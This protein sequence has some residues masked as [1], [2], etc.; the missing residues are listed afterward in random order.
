MGEI[1][2]IPIVVKKDIYLDDADLTKCSL[3][4]PYFSKRVNWDV[5]L[6][7]EFGVSIDPIKMD[8]CKKCLD[9]EKA[10]IKWPSLGE[11]KKV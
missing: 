2:S 1:K 9:A 7:S 3:S 10:Q 4:C 6:C 11:D 5:G 8:R